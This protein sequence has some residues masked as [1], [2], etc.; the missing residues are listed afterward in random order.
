MI[1]FKGVVYSLKYRE[2]RELLSEKVYYEMKHNPNIIDCTNCFNRLNKVIMSGNEIKL[3]QKDKYR[4]VYGLDFKYVEQE[5]ILE[6]V[7]RN[8]GYNY[9]K[10]WSSR[11][12]YAYNDVGE[13]IR[14]SNH[15][16]V[17]RKFG[18]KERS[19]TFGKGVIEGYELINNGFNKVNPEQEYYLY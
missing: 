6:N 10:S 11:S 1:L 13:R 3:A 14:I 12:I 2:D 15:K 18:N 16:P 8:L 19:L 7:L 9:D 5:S 4:D 17:K